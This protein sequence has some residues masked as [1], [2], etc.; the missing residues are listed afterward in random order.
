MKTPY[1]ETTNE[2]PR[3]I[4]LLVR[5]NIKLKRENQ[6]LIQKYNMM[7]LMFESSRTLLNIVINNEIDLNNEDR[8][9]LC[10][11]R[12]RLFH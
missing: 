11:N 3:S 12:P 10:N 4:R 7:K 6:D 5:N 9:E 2:T 1:R 8:Q